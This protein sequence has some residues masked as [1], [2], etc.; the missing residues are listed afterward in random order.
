MA[1]F[2]YHFIGL[3]KSFRIPYLFIGIS[4]SI[5][6][7]ICLDAIANIKLNG[8][9]SIWG[10]LSLELYLV[11]MILKKILIS[12]PL[13]GGSA[14]ANYNKYIIFVL[15]GSYMISK[16]IVYIQE[17]IILKLNYGNE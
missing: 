4:L 2:N 3:I 16:I 17:K 12:T 5:W 11:H 15:F 1:Y 13:Y 14:V 8:F 7:C 10:E 6:I 9:L